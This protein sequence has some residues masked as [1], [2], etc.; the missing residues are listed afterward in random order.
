VASKVQ[1]VQ[2]AHKALVVFKVLVA[3]KVLVVQL[4][5]K[6]QVVHKVH[7]EFKAQLGCK[8]QAVLPE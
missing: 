6:A 4:A 3:S 2:L 5:H 7:L 8:A 1:V